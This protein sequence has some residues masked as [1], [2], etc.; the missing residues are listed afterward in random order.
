MLYTKYILVE[1]TCLQLLVIDQE[2]AT[3]TNLAEAFL[4]ET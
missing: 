3:R 1:L 2:V 4:R